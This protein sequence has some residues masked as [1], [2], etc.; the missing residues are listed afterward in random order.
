MPAVLGSEHHALCFVLFLGVCLLRLL[1][2]AC[3]LDSLCCFCMFAGAWVCVRTSLL[4]LSPRLVHLASAAHTSTT[5][6][7][8]HAWMC[9]CANVCMHY[10]SDAYMYTTTN[11][12]HTC[13]H[14]HTR[15]HVY[16]HTH[17]HTHTLNGRLL[18]R[19]ARSVLAAFR[20]LAYKHL[21]PTLLYAAL[22]AIFCL[23][24]PLETSRGPNEPQICVFGMSQSDIIVSDHLWG[25]WTLPTC[26]NMP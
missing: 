1:A 11:H 10:E 9:E 19:S 17:T 25:R 20:Q 8:M 2:Y 7:N 3:I 6:T 12:T 14:T 13:V 18:L 16:T 23:E 21:S 26:S 24:W 5:A 22:G 15:T 4:V